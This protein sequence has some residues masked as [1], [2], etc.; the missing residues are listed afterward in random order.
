MLDFGPNNQYIGLIEAAV[1][2]KAVRRT[3]VLPSFTVEER[4][5]DHQPFPFTAL[6][7]PDALRKVVPVMVAGGPALEDKKLRE[8]VPDALETRNRR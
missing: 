2:A 8:E 3:L 5:P 4:M 1:V 6:F 7:D